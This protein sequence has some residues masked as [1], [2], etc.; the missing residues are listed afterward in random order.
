MSHSCEQKAQTQGPIKCKRKTDQE[1]LNRL[2][3]DQIDRLLAFEREREENSRQKPEA[4]VEDGEEVP[5]NGVH[6]PGDETISV[7][8]DVVD[9]MW[10]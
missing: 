7:P 2:V 8:Y 6:R 10:E 3:K 9:R 4:C 5:H 1:L